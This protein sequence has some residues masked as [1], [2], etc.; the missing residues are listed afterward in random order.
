[1]TSP[2]GSQF[3]ITSGQQRAVVTEVGGGLRL[4]RVGERDVVT[5]YG[6]REMA[7]ACHGAL[8]APW[9]NRIRDGRYTFAGVEHKLAISEPSLHNAIHGLV[10][11][12]RW[13]VVAQEPGRVVL[14]HDLVPQPGY[15]F[16]LRLEAAYELGDDGVAISIT[17]TN[18]GDDEAP[19]G[20]GFHPWLSPGRYRI[21]DC[22]L[23]VP[24]SVWVRADERLLP[25]EEV[26]QI[27]ADKDFS[28]PRQVGDAVLDDAFV[29][30]PTGVTTASLTDPDGVSAVVWAED[31]QAWQV[32]TGDGMP[33]GLQRSGLAVEPMSCTADA[34][35]TGDRLV[36]LAPGESHTLRCGLALRT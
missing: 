27:P 5:P 19:Y 33:D 11:Y 30:V 12:V 14:S 18:L 4:Y 24:G 20:V 32:C 9:P 17:A 2:T 31:A 6:D 15:P 29:G 1:M 8:L 21:D 36:V 13:S 34:F 28:S 35:R 23:T 25:V 10:S 3:E 7:P 22:V 26:P 16:A